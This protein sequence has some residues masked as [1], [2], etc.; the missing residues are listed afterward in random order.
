MQ[1]HTVTNSSRELKS[2]PFRWQRLYTLYIYQMTYNKG[3]NYL[4]II[5]LIMHLLYRYLLST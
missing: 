1:A 5:H 2:S 4:L 3:A